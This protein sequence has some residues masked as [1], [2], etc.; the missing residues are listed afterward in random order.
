MWSDL[1]RGTN[2]WKKMTCDIAGGGG[3]RGHSEE[4]LPKKKVT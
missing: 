4:Q 2:G 1:R 3:C